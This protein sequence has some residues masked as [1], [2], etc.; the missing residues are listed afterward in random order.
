MGLTKIFYI[1]LGTSK[2]REF[3][4]VH[5]SRSTEEGICLFGGLECRKYVHFGNR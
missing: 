3:M 1:G 2:G 5:K 4:L